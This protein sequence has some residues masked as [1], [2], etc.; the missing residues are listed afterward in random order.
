VLLERR[1]PNG[2]WGGL[3]SLPECP[4]D[5]RPEQW[6]RESLACEPLSLSPLASRR[7]TFSHFHF[8]I[9]PLVIRVNNP[10]NRVMDADDRVWYKLADSDVRGLAVPVS[11]ILDEL[12]QSS[13]GECE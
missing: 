5:Q 10:N 2:I 11:R 3:W 1:P 13:T 4:P 6:C 7:H 12:R 8:D 9:T